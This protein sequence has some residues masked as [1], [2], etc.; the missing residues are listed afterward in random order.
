MNRNVHPV[1]E[2]CEYTGDDN[3]DGDVLGAK[4][5]DWNTDNK[6][7]PSAV[8]SNNHSVYKSKL[9][10][11]RVTLLLALF[12]TAVLC[13]TLSFFILRF[14]ETQR[15]EEQFSSHSAQLGDRIENGV[16]QVVKTNA[17]TAVYTG[18]L[19]KDRSQWPF[20]YNPSFIDTY[21]RVS[22]ISTISG[23]GVAPIFNVS[24]TS[25]FEDYVNAAVTNQTGMPSNLKVNTDYGSPSENV[26]NIVAPMINIEPTGFFQLVDLVH[27]A[28]FEGQIE[29]ILD[30]VEKDSKAT[31][32]H[33]ER[34]VSISHVSTV[35]APVVFIFSPIYSYETPEEVVGVVAA[36]IVLQLFLENVSP[37][38]IS[39]IECVFYSTSG[40]GGDDTLVGDIYTFTIGKACNPLHT[41]Q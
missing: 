17:Q 22:K 41:D 25:E 28:Y 23:L 35:F 4:P 37:H 3:S 10:M 27:I 2:D 7:A 26:R 31:F 5:R 32:Q 13:G 19:Y 11:F 40:A 24:L 15:Y 14:Y 16:R 9:F 8:G 36:A 20:V 1:K 21:I 30:C 34:C 38:Y 39:G 12:I 29:S 33:T 18:L 6:E